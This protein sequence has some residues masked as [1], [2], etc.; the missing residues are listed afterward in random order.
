MKTIT[1]ENIPVAKISSLLSKLESEGITYSGFPATSGTLKGKGIV[2][3]FHYML[4]SSITGADVTIVI[5]KKPWYVSYGKIE[6]K[7]RDYLT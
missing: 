3:T 7:I 6:N 4:R 2:A 5:T 1:I